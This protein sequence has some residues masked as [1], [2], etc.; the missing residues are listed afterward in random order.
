MKTDTDTPKKKWPVKRTIAL[1]IIAI[2]GLAAFLVYKNFNRIIAD[3]LTKAFE[4]DAMSDVYELK[5]EKLLVNPFEGSIQ[6]SN[7]VLQPL[8]KPLRNYPYINSSFVLKTEK[9]M[10]KNVAIIDLLKSN[11]LHLERILIDNPEVELLLKGRHH[12]L[13]PFKDTTATSSSDTT[14]TTEARE[15]K[16]KTIDNFTL[17]Q[18]L[19]KDASFHVTNLEKQREFKIQKFNIDLLDLNISQEPGKDVMTFKQ[20]EFLIGEFAGRMEKGPVK[21]ISFK[22]YSLKVDSLKLHETLDTAI[23]KFHD[24]NTSINALDIQTA[25]SIYNLTLTSFS[26]SYRAKSLNMTGL[27]FKP[28]VDEA[29]LQKKHKYQHQEVTAAIGSLKLIDLDFDSLIASKKIFI[30]EVLLDD[31]TASLYKDK[32]KPMDS[33]RMPV[34]L[35]QTIKAIPLPLLIKKVK[36]TKV[37]LVNVERKPDSTSAKV[38]ITR[39]TVDVTNI[40]NLSTGKGLTLKAHAYIEDKAHA[41]LNITFDYV[42]TQFSFEGAAEAFVLTDLNPLILAYTPAKVNKGNVDKMAFSGI[43]RR[44]S[45]SGTMTFLYHDLEIDLELKEKAKWKSDILAFTANTILDSSN[46]NK[47]DLPPRVVQFQVDRDMN[48]GFVNIIMKSML[49]GLKETMIMSKENKKSH[50]VAKKESKEESKEESKQES[51]K[52]SK[53]VAKQESKKE[54]KKESKQ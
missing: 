16:K 54:S 1:S 29:T 11:E 7:V 20:V 46:P 9:I 17:K 19:L 24:L 38:N 41:T 6:V 28:N 35:G 14:A 47:A 32:T 52:E 15:S 50:R 33:T 30:N 18:F 42:K 31:V 36:C 26:L 12:I 4:A 37:T 39:G 2:L 51:K 53:K 5:F 21:L 43:A 44:T 25:D 10:L 49:A 34:Y 3:S 23:F 40:T 22:D 8:E 48:K 27:S 13:L 45:A